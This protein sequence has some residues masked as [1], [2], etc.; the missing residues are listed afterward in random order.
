MWKCLH[1]M[2]NKYKFVM[3]EL[4]RALL[5]KMLFMSSFTGLPENIKI[6]FLKFV[7]GFGCIIQYIIQANFQIV[8]YKVFVFVFI[9]HLCD[10]TL[11]HSE[12]NVCCHDYLLKN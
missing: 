3:L 4:Y 5:K 9:S 10:P 8:D 1:P 6:Q 12:Q 11:N 2:L 7:M